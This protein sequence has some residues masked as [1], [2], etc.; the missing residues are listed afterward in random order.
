MLA[1]LWVAALGSVVR[2][3]GAGYVQVTVVAVH[4][5]YTVVPK[6]LDQLAVESPLESVRGVVQ[7][8]SANQPSNERPDHVGTPKLNGKLSAA[9]LVAS[10]TPDPL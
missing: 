5:A 8:D 7:P 1:V 6:P 3:G 9:R 10:P 2:D 4:P